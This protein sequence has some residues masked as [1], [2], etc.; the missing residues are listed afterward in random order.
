MAF[1]IEETTMKRFL[2]MVVIFAIMAAPAVAITLPI[3]AN[4]YYV[5]TIA[6]SFVTSSVLAAQAFYNY[7]V[8]GA[9]FPLMSVDPNY[10]GS[11]AGTLDTTGLATSSFNQTTGLFN[12]GSPY[13]Y[14]PSCPNA[15]AISYAAADLSTGSLHAYG[16]GVSNASAQ[17]YAFMSDTLTFTVAGADA[18]TVTPITITWS[19]DGSWSYNPISWSGEVDAGLTLGGQVLADMLGNN[20]DP[21]AFVG[22]PDTGQSGWDSF[23]YA[24][25]TFTDIDFTGVY[26]L[27]GAS[28]T[29]PFSMS[30]LV[31][32]GGG[33][34]NGGLTA[35]ATTI[36]FSNT[37]Q[38]GL[39]LPNNVSFTSNS[40]VFLTGQPS[41]PEPA[42]L[43]LVILPLL[44]LGFLRWRRRA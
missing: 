10:S 7:S 4:G 14:C 37:G 13:P 31:W 38:V 5:E 24:S 40:G 1:N 43:S 25:D 30:L 2:M 3:G 34:A 29:L 36:D 42:T 16:Q 19:L 21:L 12:F 18:S 20:F 41:V 6:N 23:S 9:T 32:P 44:G 33:F 26:D 11:Q 35:Y 15:S 22:A 8:P 28:A 39:I 17:S 27:V